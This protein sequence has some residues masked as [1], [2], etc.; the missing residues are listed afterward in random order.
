MTPFRWLAC[1]LLACGTAPAQQILFTTLGPGESF[2]GIPSFSIGAGEFW[3]LSGNN[4]A[5]L[6]AAFTPSVTVPFSHADFALSYNYVAYKDLTGPPD[7]R[8]YSRRRRRR[9]AR[10]YNRDHPHHECLWRLDVLRHSDRF[11]RAAS[12]APA[13]RS[14][15]A[16]AC[17]SGSAA[18]RVHL[19]AGTGRCAKQSAYR[20]VFGAGHELSLGLGPCFVPAG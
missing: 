12:G 11:F 10:R 7:H 18:Y 15:L 14:I 5:I 17:A 16:G 1:A 6:A 20:P 13:R 3:N 9:R 4:G 8:R 2:P 19:D